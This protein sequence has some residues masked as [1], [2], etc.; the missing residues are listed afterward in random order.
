MT[1]N[2]QRISK[3]IYLCKK[4]CRLSGGGSILYE[5]FCAEGVAINWRIFLKWSKEWVGFTAEEEKEIEIVE[6]KLRNDPESVSP[7]FDSEFKLLEWA[8]RNGHFHSV[9][10]MKRL[11]EWEIAKIKKYSALVNSESERDRKAAERFWDGDESAAFFSIGK[12]T[13]PESVA[14]LK[15]GVVYYVRAKR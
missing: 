10:A 12:P 8:I 1:V 2:E 5:Y 11:E 7:N 15:P 3:I 9:Y 13:K 4:A 14:A 6:E